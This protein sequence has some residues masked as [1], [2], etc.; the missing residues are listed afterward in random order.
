M[1]ENMRIQSILYIYGRIAP[2]SQ[3]LKETHPV[4]GT[5]YRTNNS[6]TTDAIKLTQEMCITYRKTMK[7]IYKYSYELRKLLKC[8][9]KQK[10]G[11]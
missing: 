1:N 5:R 3:I 10:K 9:N 2:L 11:K 6:K 7:H 8:E 4:P